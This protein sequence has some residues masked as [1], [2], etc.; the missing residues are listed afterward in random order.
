MT[1][2]AYQPPPVVRLL[3]RGLSRVLDGYVGMTFTVDNFTPG[4]AGPVAHVRDH[5]YTGSGG[6]PYQIW[7]LAADDYEVIP[8]KVPVVWNAAR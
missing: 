5:R 3:E 7:S 6:Q 8:F 4:V 1:I 2:D